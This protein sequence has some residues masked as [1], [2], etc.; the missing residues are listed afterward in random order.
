LIVERGFD[1]RGCRGETRPQLGELRAAFAQIGGL[2]AQSFH[3]HKVI[4][5]VDDSNCPLAGWR[6]SDATLFE[7]IGK[8]GVIIGFLA[9]R[10]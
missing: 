6:V 2:H 8:H 1:T 10:R 5:T 9:K 4:T 3:H 7:L